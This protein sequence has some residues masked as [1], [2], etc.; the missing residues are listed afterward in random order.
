MEQATP[1]TDYDT[2]ACCES[3]MIFLP[4]RAVVYRNIQTKI[5]AKSFYLWTKENGTTLKDCILYGVRQT[6]V[7]VHLECVSYRRFWLCLRR[8][9]WLH[10]SS[11]AMGLRLNYL[12]LTHRLITSRWSMT[13]QTYSSSIH[14]LTPAAGTFSQLKLV[15][16]F[17]Q[18]ECSDYDVTHTANSRCVV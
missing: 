7:L 2:N 8:A 16:C 18:A 15:L 14:P 9:V 17:H 6:R 5:A 10:G 12:P 3:C 1:M 13:A 11:S 4:M